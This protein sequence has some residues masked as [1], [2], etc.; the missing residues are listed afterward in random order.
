MAV[1]RSPYDHSHGYGG[2]RRIKLNGIDKNTSVNQ[3]YVAKSRG[4]A[5]PKGKNVRKTKRKT[6]S[7][8]APTSSNSTSLVFSVKTWYNNP[9]QKR[10]RRMAKYKIYSIEGKVKN[11]FKKGYCWFKRKCFYI[12]HGYH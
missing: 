10:K 9:E 3:M 2:D 11:T 1:L 5:P 12:I 6:S 8:S 4:V 7:S